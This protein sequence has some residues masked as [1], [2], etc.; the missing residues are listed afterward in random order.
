ML[1]SAFHGR[2][3]KRGDAECKWSLRLL[4]EQLQIELLAHA[5]S[6]FAHFFPA[7]LTRALTDEHFASCADFTAA[8]EE[9]QR[10]R[11]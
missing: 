5:R 4:A 9:T 8:F 3:R 11:V 10:L 6:V 1:R 7:A 2:A